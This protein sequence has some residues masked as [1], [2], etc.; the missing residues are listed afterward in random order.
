[1]CPLSNRDWISGGRIENQKRP[2]GVTGWWSE[3]YL[4]NV[5]KI[6][7]SVDKEVCG[8]TAAVP[9]EK[10]RRGSLALKGSGPAVSLD[11][12]HR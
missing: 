7:Q 12:A 6:C 11:T 1:M 5:L 3:S 4:P 8:H 9:G 10:T 2:V